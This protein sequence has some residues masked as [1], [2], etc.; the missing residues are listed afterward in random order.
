MLSA[1]KHLRLLLS[2]R[3]FIE[4]RNMPRAKITEN[5]NQDQVK[6]LAQKELA[7]RP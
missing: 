6:E 2:Q 1:A 4:R 7:Q 5:L 3:R